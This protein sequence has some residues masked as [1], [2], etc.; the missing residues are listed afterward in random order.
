MKTIVFSALVSEIIDKVRGKDRISREIERE[1]DDYFE[2]CS[3]G[4]C[5][6]NCNSQSYSIEEAME[7]YINFIYCSLLLQYHS[8]MNIKVSEFIEE[9]NK[10]K[11][12]I[13]S[14]I[15]SRC[16]DPLLPSWIKEFEDEFLMDH[17]VLAEKIYGSCDRSPGKI[18]RL[19]RRKN[20]RFSKEGG[21]DIPFRENTLNNKK[22]VISCIWEMLCCLEALTLTEEGSGKK[23]TSQI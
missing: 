19:Y 14:K 15:Q 18:R 3:L 7:D 2:D 9:M 23:K 8:S 13:T 11:T 4:R 12:C 22:V 16:H 6:T 17:Y 21:I 1:I 10:L 5:I 20:N